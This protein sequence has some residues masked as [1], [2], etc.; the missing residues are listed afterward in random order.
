MNFLRFLCLAAMV[1]LIGITAASADVLQLPEG[2]TSLEFV[3]VGDAGNFADT[4][5]FGAVNYDYQIGKYHVTAAQYVEFLNA[6]AKTDTHGLY[7]SSMS[8]A[9]DC[10][11][12][13]SGDSGSYT[14]SVASE[15][16]N[17]PV[18]YMSFSNAVRFC[19]WLTNGQPTGDQDLT[20]TEDGSYYLNGITDKASLLMVTRE[21][22]AVYVLPSL[23][24]WYKAAY[25]DPDKPGGAGY[26][27]YPTR[28][29]S[30][31]TAEAP[32]GQTT[33]SA[34]YQSIMG[35][36]QLTDVGAYTYSAGPYGTYDQGGLLYQWTDSILTTSYSGFAMM[37]S[38]FL[39]SSSDQL[40]SDYQVWPWTPTN[41]FNFNGFRVAMVPEPST[42]SLLVL[43][44]V[45]LLGM[46][47]S[48]KR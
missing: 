6:V 33:G 1:S 25:Y 36:D 24:E 47:W 37:N 39:S 11:I 8:G 40:R 34:N 43:G 15:S 3:P 9:N 14:Y 22:D 41:E 18:N 48:R 29:D 17:H 5:G 19:N 31:P 2:Q 44:T 7:T 13:R 38:S 20:T 28:S 45:M 30:A 46:R 4:T 35:A 32:P 12:Q 42:I 23:N 21:A 26:W 27:D 10:N 16:A